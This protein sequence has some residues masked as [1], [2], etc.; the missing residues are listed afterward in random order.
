MGNNPYYMNLK[1]N[2]FNKDMTNEDRK[3]SSFIQSIRLEGPIS[4][5]KEIAKAFLETMEYVH[6]NYKMDK[7]CIFELIDD[8]CACGHKLTKKD[9][10][11]KEINLPGGSSIFLKFY[12]YSCS[13]CNK[14]VDRKL[15]YLF[16]PNKQYSKNIK[17][18][19]VRLY[20]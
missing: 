16:E 2:T 8:N 4:D 18:D 10:Y 19:A 14:P 17:A 12:R 11:E 6:A 7:E 13:H 1:L 20:S 5:D 3:A 15:S 9:I